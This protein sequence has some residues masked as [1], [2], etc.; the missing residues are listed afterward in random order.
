MIARLKRRLLT[1]AGVPVGVA[2][3]VAILIVGVGEILLHLHPSDP[4][5]ELARPE[6]WGALG[7]ALA[8]LGLGAFAA[9]RPSGSMGVLDREVVVGDR[10]FF[11]PEPPPLDVT[12]RRGEPGTIADIR[13]GDTLYARNGPLARV[14]AM[15]PAEEEFG[16]RYRGLIYAEGLYGASAELF[17]P[18]EAV[19]AVYP[20]THSA[21]LAIK[22]DETE[23]FGWNRAPESFRRT[24]PRGQ[25]PGP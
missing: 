23:H 21:F 17:I 7:G 9:T 13:P 6:L 12:L 2:I 20:E 18:V 25:L 19:F 11:A 8:V 4:S 5:S 14:I 1:A 3:A 24:P 10:P 22:G 16:R 15:L